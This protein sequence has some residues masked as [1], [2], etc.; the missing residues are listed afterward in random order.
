MS[1]ASA[2][3][4]RAVKLV[5]AYADSLSDGKTRLSDSAVSAL[6]GPGD[7]ATK[8]LVIA[9]ME[10]GCEDMKLAA[11]GTGSVL[12]MEDVLSRRL[13]WNENVLPHLTDAFAVMISSST[14]F[15]PVLNFRPAFEHAFAIANEA[16]YIAQPPPNIPSGWYTHR[17]VIAAIYAA[18][19]LHQLTSPQSAHSFLQSL[20]FTSQQLGKVVSEME[21]YGGFII[22]G[23]AEMLKG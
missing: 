6:F 7:K 22:K 13:R 4:K 18:T 16:C 20:L 9:W 19:E 21:P 10:E 14:P 11:S 5:P 12:G 8:A 17:A 1:S 15:V 2:I 23:W 3:L